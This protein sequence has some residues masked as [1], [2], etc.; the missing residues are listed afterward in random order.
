MSENNENIENNEQSS[1]KN[2]KSS[3]FGRAGKFA[4]NAGTKTIAKVA[5]GLH[6]SNPVAIGI[7]STLCGTGVL[8]LFGIAN[9]KND[10]PIYNDEA[11][12]CEQ[13][14]LEDLGVGVPSGDDISAIQNRNAAIIYDTLSELGYSDN[15]ITGLVACMLVECNM[16]ASRLESDYIITDAKA[17]FE[18]VAG[19]GSGADSATTIHA[20]ADYCR[21]F[22]T[23]GGWNGNPFYK[24]NVEGEGEIVACGIGLIQWTRGR[25]ISIMQGIDV[26]ESKYS[27]MD[28]EYQL[29]YLLAEIEKSYNML[30]PTGDWTTY[31]TD[32]NTMTYYIFSKLVFGK[33]AA[34]TEELQKRLD[35]VPQAEALIAAQTV[36]NEFNAEVTSIAELLMDG[37]LEVA[38]K[39]NATANNCTNGSHMET[40]SISEAALSIA[41]LKG[42]HY[43]NEEAAYNNIKRA[44]NAQNIINDWDY[45]EGFNNAD[46]GTET[47]HTVGHIAHVNNCPY[48]DSKH[49]LIACTEYYYFAHLLVLPNELGTAG[50]MGF[51]SSCDRGVCVPVRMSG[52]D[53]K[54]P[55]G[56]PQ[57]QL[58]YMIGSKRTGSDMDKWESTG[59]FR[60][61]DLYS[62][63]GATTLTP[64]TILCTWDNASANNVLS[65]SGT[66]T[67]TGSAEL[68]YYN[69][70]S[71]AQ[72]NNL[73]FAPASTSTHDHIILYVGDAN[74]KKYYGEE[75]LQHQFEMFGANND[76]ASKLLKGDYTVK[77]LPE[78]MKLGLEYKTTFATKAHDHKYTFYDA[79]KADEDEGLNLIL[80]P[81]TNREAGFNRKTG[82]RNFSSYFEIRQA[83]INGDDTANDPITHT[84]TYTSNLGSWRDYYSANS[85]W[86]YELLADY[87]YRALQ[88][89]RFAMAM[90]MCSNPTEED[91]NIYQP[92]TSTYDK[93]SPILGN[94]YRDMSYHTGWSSLTSSS[95]LGTH[96]DPNTAKYKLM[97]FMTPTQNDML[98]DLLQLETKQGVGFL[99]DGTYKQSST[100][101]SSP[102]NVN[103]IVGKYGITGYD[104]K[105][106][107]GLMS[108]DLAH[109]Y[110]LA[111]GSDA[112][113]FNVTI[114]NWLTTGLYNGVNLT[115]RTSDRTKIYGDE[116]FGLN[117]FVNMTTTQRFD[118][119]NKYFYCNLDGRYAMKVFAVIDT[120]NDGKVSY[121]QMYNAANAYDL[122]W[123]GFIVAL[124]Y[125]D[126][127]SLPGSI[128]LSNT[129][130]TGI[131]NVDSNHSPNL[132]APSWTNKTTYD[133]MVADGSI[134]EY[135]VYSGNGVLVFDSTSGW[136]TNPNYCD[137]AKQYCNGDCRYTGNRNFPCEHHQK[138]CA[139]GGVDP[140]PVHEITCEE[141]GC[142]YDE[143]S[144]YELNCSHRYNIDCSEA[145]GCVPYNPSGDYV[146]YWTCGHSSSAHSP[147]TTPGCY[148][149]KGECPSIPH[150][151]PCDC[152]RRMECPIEGCETNTSQDL[153]Y[154]MYDKCKANGDNQFYVVVKTMDPGRYDSREIG[155]WDWSDIE[156]KLDIVR[157]TRG[158][159]ATASDRVYTVKYDSHGA[160][161]NDYITSGSDTANN[162]K[163][164]G[165]IIAY[166]DASGRILCNHEPDSNAVGSG[167]DY[168]V[169]TKSCHSHCLAATQS[170]DY[171]W[172]HAYNENT[173]M[174]YTSTPASPSSP[175]ALNIVPQ[176]YSSDITSLEYGDSTSLIYLVAG[177]DHVAHISFKQTNGEDKDKKYIDH[178][179]GKW[180]SSEKDSHDHYNKPLNVKHGSNIVRTNP[181]DPYS[182]YVISESDW[183]Y[184]NGIWVTHA[185]RGDR[186]VMAEYLSPELSFGIPGTGRNMQY[187]LFRNKLKGSCDLT[188]PDDTCVVYDEAL[189]VV[190]QQECK[191]HSHWKKLIEAYNQRESLTR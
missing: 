119:I 51:F 100:N 182:P 38:V 71:L 138:S 58:S 30:S 108:G 184:D 140:N 28:T 18:S 187:M 172:V 177:G 63:S 157:N 132:S 124:S 141:A 189:G 64:D 6:V 5:T 159:I 116:I 161:I 87:E 54:Y 26:I 155:D 111:M 162:N 99:T 178:C 153:Y 82:L 117:P 145:A 37:S 47:N 17:Q 81:I 84:G 191:K 129:G 75:F 120:D 43:E 9:V 94:I 151:K 105:V 185:S 137:C 112:D 13:D 125:K 104:Y 56:D 31:D 95:T 1:S 11:W 68:G 114:R 101:N 142:T 173:K 128:L 21:V 147:S 79:L 92:V 67:G 96:Y 14:E 110:M 2:K 40:V 60:G 176:M 183:D 4:K 10:A 25:A 106:L 135:R 78:A 113:L 76:P 97:Y 3:L 15:F 90:M 61:Y 123:N 136:A 42:G 190:T 186:G 53:D 73:R 169:A 77:E 163:H 160:I 55:A 126:D 36:T 41:W 80:D 59:F 85:E 93:D 164:N 24:L 29:A 133:E 149:D 107:S 166:F 156:N 20:Y 86:R 22:A 143:T 33:D 103:S 181:D 134:L 174:Y 45:I 131:N 98:Q 118:F 62:Y 19:I 16:D 152:D 66:G 44:I 50:K 127:S 171:R 175:Y 122:T 52:S 91:A 150:T 130:R 170:L 57:E 8:G 144:R 121:K 88:F 12:V 48:G 180:T 7:V 139:Q 167:A 188:D 23:D 115:T 70:L 69:S 168:T 34:G 148:I 83:I 32:I 74:I 165:K 72:W 146:I 89:E 46:G 35:K 39:K 109:T 158:P 27:I 179:T 49:D 102:T 65:I 154:W